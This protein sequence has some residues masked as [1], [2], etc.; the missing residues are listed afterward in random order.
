MVDNFS[1]ISGAFNCFSTRSLCYP[2]LVLS[3]SPLQ[4]AA[5]T[6]AFPLV[7]AMMVMEG[8]SVWKTLA[9][10]AVTTAVKDSMGFLIA[11]VRK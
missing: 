9:D 8:V 3:L 2:D 5:V 1:F 6:G 4:L 7:T 11:N 10:P